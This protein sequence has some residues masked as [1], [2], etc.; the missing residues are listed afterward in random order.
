M[1]T[2]R[3]LVAVPD[4]VRS[5][6]LDRCAPGGVLELIPE[7][8]LAVRRDHGHVARHLNLELLGAGIENRVAHDG[9]QIDG[10]FVDGQEIQ[11]L[12][13]HLLLA[14][15]GLGKRQL[16]RVT[17]V[18]ATR[19]SYSMEPRGPR[20]GTQRSRLTVTSPVFLVIQTW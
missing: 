3:N 15:L 19:K 2:D 9:E 14:T 17:G 4:R 18:R 6:S 7:G 12:G 11:A 8:A 16:N 13:V 10:A 5:L 1:Q 20:A